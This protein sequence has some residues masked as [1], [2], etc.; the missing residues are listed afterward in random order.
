M[1]IDLPNTYVCPL[2]RNAVYG[3]LAINCDDFPDHIQRHIYEYGL[4]QILNDAMADKKDEDGNP[5]ANGEIRAKA[6]KRLDTL[7]RGEIRS[8]SEPADPIEAETVKLAKAAIIK[9]SAGGTV[10]PIFS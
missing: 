5:L 7:L 8:R 10:V 6:E 2:G 4:R 3:T 9:A 1:K